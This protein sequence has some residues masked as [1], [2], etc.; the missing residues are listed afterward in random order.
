MN[1]KFYS[2]ITVSISSLFNGC[3]SHVKT[4]LQIYKL[5]LA[6][7][8][9]SLVFKTRMIKYLLKKCVWLNEVDGPVKML[10]MFWFFL[11]WQHSLAP[12][13]KKVNEARVVEMANKLCNKLLNGKDQHRDIASIALKTVIAEVCT[14]SLAQSILVSIL[15]HLIRGITGPV[16]S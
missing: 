11:T 13:V 6:A 16:S 7:L 1:L 2:Y 4:R 12:L 15:P 8:L 14:E 9:V 3:M 10:N 5:I